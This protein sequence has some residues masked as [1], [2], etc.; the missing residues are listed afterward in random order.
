MAAG[1]AAGFYGV[2][3]FPRVGNPGAPQ[4]RIAAG[5]V[6]NKRMAA[7]D[8]ALKSGKTEYEFNFISP[9]PILGKQ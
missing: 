7:I 9:S 1:F 2:V 5:T 3:F 8:R 4:K 6:M